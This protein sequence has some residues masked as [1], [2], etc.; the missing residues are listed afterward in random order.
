MTITVNRRHKTHFNKKCIHRLMQI[1]YLKSV[2][3]RK[4]Y[5]YIKSTPE[6]TAKNV[7]NRE[8]YADAPNEKWLTDITEFKC[9]VG[10]EVRKVYLSAIFD[11]HIVSYN[12]GTSNNNQLVFETFNEA[13]ESNPTAH[14]LFHSGRGFQ[15]TNKA[16]HKMLMEAGMRQSMSK[17]GRCIDNGS[18]E[19]F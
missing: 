2:C 18:M 13:V 15:Y 14:P 9:Y 5:N 1:L 6:I 11:R 7:F 3:R 17:V 10:V 12:I 4:R 19:D 8:F 16:L